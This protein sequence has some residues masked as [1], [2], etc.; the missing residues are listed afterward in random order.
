MLEQ[1]L[2]AR[3]LEERLPAFLAERIALSDLPYL[4]D[5][6]LR[7]LGLSMAE[8]GR[9]RR[10]L[11]EQ[12]QPADATGLLGQ[13]KLVAPVQGER[14]PLTVMFVDIVDFVGLGEQ[15]G[16]EE[17]LDVIRRFREVSGAAV[18]RTGGRITKFLGDGMLACFCHPVANENDP[19]RA[20]RAGLEIVAAVAA[21]RPYGTRELA[22]RI[23]IATGSVI[24]SDL[25]EG[26]EPE[27][28]SVTGSALNLAARLQAL[29]PPGGVVKS[30]ST[31]RRVAHLFDS[32]D[33]GL[34]EIRGLKHAVRCWRVR[35]EVEGRGGVAPEGVAALPIHGREPELEILDVL[36]RNA[37][38]GIGKAALLTGEAGVG[39]TALVEEF[40]R[41]HGLHDEA[42][43]SLFGSELD[44]DT[45]FHPVAL[46]LRARAGKDGAETLRH[47]LDGLAGDAD[48][49][50]ALVARVAGLPFDGARLSGLSLP[51]QRDRTLEALSEILLA[52]ARNGPICLLA[53]DLH[54]MDPSTIELLS[55]LIDRLD[56]EKL[57][58]VMTARLEFEA[59][60]PGQGVVTLSVG[61]LN[62]GEVRAMAADLIGTSD[63]PASLVAQ[64]VE[65]TDGVPLF[66]QEVV[67]RLSDKSHGAGPPAWGDLDAQDVPSSLQ[68]ALMGR[69]DRTGSAKGNAQ[70]A[71]VIGRRVDHALLNAVV[72]MAEDELDASL[73][74]LVG[75][76]V[77]RRDGDAG[78][79]SFSHALVRDIAYA[80]L[81]R[82]AR[83]RLHGRVADALKLLHPTIAEDHPATMATHLTEAGRAGVAGRLWL[84]AGRR[85]L[86][87]S[88]L[89]E[90]TRL[91]RRGLAAIATVEPSPDRN[92][93]EVE[94]LGLLGPALMSL[95]GPGAADTCEHYER[96]Y[97]LCQTLD[98]EPAHFPLYWGWW[99]VAQD[100]HAMASRSSWLLHRAKSHQDAG[101]LLQ[102]HHCNWATSYHVGDFGQCC[103]HIEAGLG[104]YGDADW[105]HHAPLYGNHDA[106]ACAHGELA[107]LHYMQGRPDGGRTHQRHSLAWARELRHL[108]S[109]MHSMDVGLTFHAMRRS[110]ADVWRASEELTALTTEHGFRDHAAKS[111]IYRGWAR[112][113]QED[114][115]GGL[116]LLQEGMSMQRDS[117]TSEDSPIYVCLLAEA[118]M[119]AGQPE[120]AVSEL[121]AARE[122]FA[123]IGL[124]VWLPEVL[125]MTAAAMAASSGGAVSPVL[126]EAARV[127]AQQAVPM[128]GLRIANDRTNL[129]AEAGDPEAAEAILT[130]ALAA[131]PSHEGVEFADANA[132]LAKLRGR[133]RRPARV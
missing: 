96:S 18:L 68:E 94:L 51:Q 85:A 47:S 93:L 69:L 55:R 43:V 37:A 128:L 114:A 97:A 61:R 110:H 13:A 38:K 117:G 101:V 90:A 92:R 65:R 53:E 102:A 106:R 112:A 99:R 52:S 57:L 95:S 24:L 119:A 77:L 63:I 133:L 81:L 33:L 71:A 115:A 87:A 72:D 67:R 35:G 46:H 74:T 83:R 44:I 25:F 132:R 108:G 103:E 32:D 58:A 86:E 109:L 10:V 3:G 54:W 42:L 73:E 49:A 62:E 34:H 30:E 15:V 120:G 118:L 40:V 124:R 129:L 41:R 80:S 12:R 130:A 127:A 19:Q 20:V 60:W 59:P 1:W 16:D 91:L 2:R 6:D 21:I 66:V 56:R 45:P 17:M 125:R 27:L 89:T 31:R 82:D 4:T 11:A 122:Q 84:E 76:G 116:R 48:E 131:L 29:A 79:F 100:F 8:R 126:E 39:K 14:R 50:M 104:L 113:V 5:D 70:A 88:A 111:R 98:E 123:Q 75:G 64:I 9:F 36:W 105:R 78:G 107:L 7:Q 121:L 28:Q 23:G 26:G 22:V